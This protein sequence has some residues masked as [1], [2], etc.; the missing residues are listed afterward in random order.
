EDRAGRRVVRVLDTAR[1]RCP[2]PL[3]A[4]GEACIVGAV[5]QVPQSASLRHPA[6][7]QGR[8]GAVEA[9]WPRD[10]VP[11]AVTRGSR[12]LVCAAIVDPGSPG[13]DGRPAVVAVPMALGDAV[14]IIILLVG[15]CQARPSDGVAVVVQPVANLG[16][17]RVDTGIRV[18][19]VL[20]APGG[21]V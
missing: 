6:E 11:H 16:S 8:G 17:A 7:L 19:A 18:V 4:G 10:L 13:V 5:D 21:A 14:A 15:A 1:A 9:G 3:A 20:P 12:T 2:I